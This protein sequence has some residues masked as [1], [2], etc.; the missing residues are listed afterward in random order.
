LTLQRIWLALTAL[1]LVGCASTQP[2]VNAVAPTAGPEGAAAQITYRDGSVE[3]ISQQRLEQFQ[4][5]LYGAPEQPAPAEPVLNELI[6]RQLM[7]RLARNSDVVAE[8]QEIERAVENVRSNPQLC[9]SRV[10]QEPPAPNSAESRAYLDACAQAFGFADGTDLRNFIAEEL[11]I[12]KI[13]QQRAPKDLIRA[14]HILFA[15]ENY[16]QA[17]TTYQ[18]LQRGEADFTALAKE[19]SIEPAA[20]QSGGELPPFNEQGLTVDG[21]PFDT[22]FVSQTLA[23][24]PAYLERGEAISQPFETQFGWHIVKILGLEASREASQNFRDAVLQRARDAQPTDLNTADQG[25]IPLIGRAEVLIDFPAP[26]VVP[27]IEVPVV[28]EETPI[29]EATSS[30]PEEGTVTPDKTASPETTATP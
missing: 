5:Q 8:A 1:L 17:A 20:Q 14:A 26:P 15:P 28:P 24:R 12:D 29:P 4:T 19:L 21:Q 2:G 11:T 30:V 6:T 25:E 13:A 23:L 27:T 9:G 18:R 3:Y 7:L 10:Q 22:T 16:E